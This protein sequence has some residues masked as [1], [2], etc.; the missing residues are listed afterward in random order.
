[1]SPSSRSG[2]TTPERASRSLQRWRGLPVRT[3]L[4]SLLVLLTTLTLVVSG[5]T[6]Y[7]LQRTAINQRIDDSL[8]RSV[9]EYRILAQEGVDP[10]TGQPFT[11]ADQLVFVAMQRTMPARNEGMLGFQGGRITWTANDAVELRLENDP[12][13]VQWALDNSDRSSTIIESVR[14]TVTDYRGV[15]VVVQLSGDDT[16]A[17]LLLAYDHEAEL[18]ELENTFL[19]YSLVGL[20]VVLLVC[21]IGWVLMGRLL[22]PLRDLQDTA[23][24]ISATDLRRRVPVSG[25]DDVAELASTFNQMLDRVEGA[26]DSQR[27][28]LDDVGHELRTPITIVQGNL[29]IQDVTD[30]EDV[31]ESRDTAL[32]ELDRMRRLVDDLVTLAKAGRP[33]FVDREPTD[34]QELTRAVVAKASQ[35]GTRVWTMDHAADVVVP[36]DAQRITQ[37]WLQLA[38]NAVRYSE[39][40]TKVSIGSQVLNGTLR[41]WVRDQGIGIA[42]EDQERIFERFGR[43]ANSTRSEG[44][45]LGLN[46]VTAIVRAHGGTVDVQSAPGVGSTFYLDLPAE[47]DVDAPDDGQLHPDTAPETLGASSTRGFGPRQ[48]QRDERA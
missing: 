19:T 7:G 25:S 32:D 29:E 44:S 13:L 10:A 5:G 28:L 48:D 17:M 34:V 24:E 9:E 45:G 47:G 11:E 16:P 3:R 42:P 31:A 6:A 14:T 35:L 43:G 39:E 2:G 23:S 22:R 46:I 36:L 8:E 41:L 27:Q 38:S 21:L 33:D 12:E 37:A 20:G 1:M 26:V 30:P 4:M 18:D 15:L 40:G